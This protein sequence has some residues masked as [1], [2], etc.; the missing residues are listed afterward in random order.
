MLI[1]TAPLLG[2]A[3]IPHAT[4]ARIVERAAMGVVPLFVVAPA[5]PASHVLPP[6]TVM[7]E[8]ATWAAMMAPADACPRSTDPSRTAR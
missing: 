3:A 4:T 2:G 8:L 1:T 7:D 6:L 5:T